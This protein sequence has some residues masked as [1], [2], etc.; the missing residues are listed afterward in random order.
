MTL[1]NLLTLLRI[2]LIPFFVAAF[3]LPIASAH[4][5]A[6]G[7]FVCAAFTD[8]L[9]GYI[10][11]RYHLKTAFGAF[12]DPVADKLM[13]ATA[14]VLILGERGIYF[15]AVPAAVIVGREIAISALREW[16]A[17]M[18][19]RTSIAVSQ[20]G[21]IKTA[22][23]LVAL[24][25]LLLYNPDGNTHDFVVMCLGTGLLYAAAVL[26]LWSMVLYLKAAWPDL[27]ASLEKS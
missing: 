25:L 2:F 15:L 24:A 27:M 6:T 19:K 4:Y 18:G 13:V 20:I 1:P 11:K 8:W 21:K 16:M 17:E 12:L 23:Q 10:A 14:L 5:L 3:Y 7:I 22:L 9:D 26:T